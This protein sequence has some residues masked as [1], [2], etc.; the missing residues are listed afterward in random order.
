[1]QRRK[2][3]RKRHAKK[4]YLFIVDG[5]TEMWYLQL[6][7]KYENFPRID[8]KPEL[9]KKKKLNE[10][11]ELVSSYSLI[12]DKVYWL[13]DLDI[14][15]QNDQVD[16]LKVFITKL[17]K[18]NSVVVLINNPCLEFWFLIHFKE[19]AKVF[20][21]CSGVESELKKQK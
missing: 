2:N 9:A 7:K 3:S 16:Q 11:F 6:M 14:I 15:L 5:Q 13:I 20:P 12:Y 19:T 4:S 18:N 17:K 21:I 10:L 1:M 8:I